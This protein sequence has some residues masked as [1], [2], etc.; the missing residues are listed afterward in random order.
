MKD[1][2][3]KFLLLFLITISV[4]NS[5]CGKNLHAIV[6]ANT[7]DPKIGTSVLLDYYSI[8]VE[9]STIA[10]ATGMQL[11][12]YYYKDEQCCNQKLREVLR[13][14]KTNAEDVILFYYT[15]HGTRSTQDVSEFPQMCLGSV[16][17]SDFY[18]LEK[19]LKD[20]DAQPARLKIVL[21]DCCN[22]IV[23]GVT[24][25]DYATR[26]VT[27]LTKEP[28]SVY[29]NL[30]SNIQGSLIASGSRKGEM[31]VCINFTDSRS[32]GGAFTYSFLKVL[33]TFASN[34]LITSWDDVMS[35]TQSVTYQLGKHTPVYSIMVKE[36]TAESEQVPYH[37]PENTAV[38]NGSED[39]DNIT[40][41]TAIGNESLSVEERIKLQEKSLKTLFNNPKV[42]VEIVGSNGTT[43][44]ATE[45]AED[46]VLRLCTT[47]RLINLVEV[48]KKVD[49]LGRYTQLKVHEIYK[50]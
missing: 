41:L 5:A 23:N 28:V 22:N 40:L 8:S 17:D 38:D 3:L 20:L 9:V 35:N 7:L 46:F 48:D 12:K 37:E 14:L 34:G 13:Q 42:K 29:N 18:P 47:H 43:I 27:V 31:S 39:T 45:T 49:S 33:E 6:F 2:F 4:I 10:A 44:V 26:T 24:P 11:K 36:A 21:G 32:A 1:V 25:K 15:G 16:Y 30:F 19:V 50:K